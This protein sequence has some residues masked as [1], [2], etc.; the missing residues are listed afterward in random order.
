MVQ[1]IKLI[2]E[3]IKGKFNLQDLLAYGGMPS[4]HAA[5]VASLTTMV[6]L[7]EGVNSTFFAISLVFSILI[8]R[9]SIGF[10]RILGSQSKEINIISKEVFNG[11]KKTPLL[12]ERVSHS[13]LEIAVGA[14]LGW[15]L[16]LFLNSLIK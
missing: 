6:A 12:L 10:R 4:G 9:D 8:I 1:F 5:F 2:P 16:T 3:A 7:K 14:I 11:D 13:L 15:L